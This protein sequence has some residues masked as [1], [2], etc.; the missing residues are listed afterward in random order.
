MYYLSPISFGLS[1][2]VSDAKAT[3]L[4]ANPNTVDYDWKLAEL[5]TRK[6]VDQILQKL[7]SQKCNT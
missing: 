6:H 7:G 3:A 5:N 2:H 1:W 4:G